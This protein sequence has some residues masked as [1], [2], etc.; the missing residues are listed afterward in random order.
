M[1]ENRILLDR[2]TSDAKGT[3]EC[4][5]ALA[6]MIMSDSTLPTFVCLDGDLGTG[7]TVFAKGFVSAVD[8]G[9][10]VTSPSY[11]LVNEYTCGSIPIFHFDVY[12][13][14]NGD[15]LYSTG[16]YDYPEDGIILVEWASLIDYAL[17]AER[18]EIKIVKTSPKDN[19]AE[20]RITAVIVTE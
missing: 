11:T 14:K 3:A 1:S 15:D 17:P 5:S 7:K 16:F 13:I 8:P 2:T 20:R 19:P 18:I 12:R 10:D 6:R 9:A 4:G